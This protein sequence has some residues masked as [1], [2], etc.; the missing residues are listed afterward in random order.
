LSVEPFLSTN[1]SL[2]LAMMLRARLL[3]QEVIAGAWCT[4]PHPSVIE[5]M[6]RLDF[7]FL[8][9]DSEHSSMDTTD[10]C[11]LLPATELHDA[12]TIFRPRSHSAGEMKAALDAG[13]SGIM[14]PMIDT[15]EAAQ[16]V[17]DVCRY[18]PL[19]SRGIGPWRA[20]GYYDDFLDYTAKANDATTLIL[21]I[22]SATGLENVERIA[23]V[24]GFEALYVGP[25]DLASSLRLPIGERG[26]EMRAALRR[27]AKAARDQGKAAGIDVNSPSDL[28][29][30]VAMGFTLFTIGSDAGFIQASGRDLTRELSTQLSAMMA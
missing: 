16:A 15:A 17:I 29:E 22:E 23:A 25:A 8:L 21:Q 5:L 10:L 13:V 19:G 2:S 12:P 7:G 6:A 14:V 9:L 11:A 24:P 3:R 30:M 1:K 20:S 18:A 4:V 28:P 26:E 27:V